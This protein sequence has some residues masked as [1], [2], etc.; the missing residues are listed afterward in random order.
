MWKIIIDSLS[1][2]SLTDFS[3]DNIA[4]EEV[5]GYFARA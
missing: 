5:E 2:I 4:V 3:H 1:R